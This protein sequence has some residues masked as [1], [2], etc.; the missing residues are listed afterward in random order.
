[1]AQEVLDAPP[2]SDVGLARFMLRATL[3]H[4]T[5]Y[6]VCGLFASVLFDYRSW[7]DTE[8]LSHMRPLS[9]PWVAAGP[10]LQVVRGLV[11]GFVLFPFRAAALGAPRGWL[12][13]WA[14]LVGLGIVSTYGPSPGSLEGVVYTTLSPPFHLFGLPEVLVQSFAFSA[15]LVGW[16]RRPSRAWAI[17]FGIGTGL[18]L[19]MS[20]AGVFLA[21]PPP[22]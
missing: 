12:A 2:P 14:L 3:C 9:S 6:M 16:C 17:V 5:T 1:M 7:W 15:C 8:S 20:L 10:A 22:G 4:V 21:P 11:F 19:L 18:T 13:L